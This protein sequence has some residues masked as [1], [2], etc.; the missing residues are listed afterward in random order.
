[1][2]SSYNIG[3][4]YESLVRG[5]VES[6]RY[7]SASEVVRDAL[8]LIEEREQQREA[9]LD[10]LRAAIRE[11]VESG[12]TIPADQVVERLTRR[13]GKGGH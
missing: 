13:Y 1:M 7:A 3:E 8:R 6:G 2:P 12:P 9:K 10:A 5:L 4:R 11:G